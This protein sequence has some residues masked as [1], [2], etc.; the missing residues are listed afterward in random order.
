[1]RV[2]ST[3]PSRP[4]GP[5][6]ELVTLVGLCWKPPASA[7][8]AGAV[9]VS[10]KAAYEHGTKV[11]SRRVESSRVESSRVE[12]S[13]VESNRIESKRNETSIWKAWQIPSFFSPPPLLAHCQ[14][15]GLPSRVAQFEWSSGSDSRSVLVS[16]VSPKGVYIKPY[17][18][19][20]G[21]P[22]AVL[23]GSQKREDEVGVWTSGVRM[24]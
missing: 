1:M 20:N 18:R 5:F 23:Q 15:I 4:P 11:G 8:W 17:I 13:R 22:Q 12:S 7:A 24:F 21:L 6:D 9:H 10:S 19:M 16:D 2:E 3:H 14:D